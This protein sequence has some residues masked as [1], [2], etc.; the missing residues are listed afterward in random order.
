MHLS[1]DLGGKHLLGH[2]QDSDH[3]IGDSD[4]NSFQHCS[5]IANDRNF[6]VCLWERILGST[7]MGRGGGHPRRIHIDRCIIAM[8]KSIDKYGIFIII[9]Q[10]I[11]TTNIYCTY[12][13]HCFIL[14]TKTLGTLILHYS[15]IQF[16][17]D[18]YVY[19]YI[20]IPVYNILQS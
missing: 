14:F 17:S 4:S 5:D 2:P 6:Y 13:F 19:V 11:K 20:Y 12:K 8:G 16:S 10:F 1:V 3:D 15:N 9:L 18:I 7:V